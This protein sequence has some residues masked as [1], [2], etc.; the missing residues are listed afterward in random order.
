MGASL[1][2]LTEGTNRSRH[3]PSLGDI[4]ESCVACVFMYLTLLEICNVVR[5]NRAFREIPKPLEEGYLYYTKTGPHRHTHVP[6]ISEYCK[7]QTA[8]KIQ[9]PLKPRNPI[10]ELWWLFTISACVKLLLIP[11]YKSTDFEVHRHWLAITHSLPLSQ[12]Y[13]DKTSILT[14]DYPPFFTYFERFLSVFANLI[15]PQIVHLQKG[16][17][18]SSNTVLYFQRISVFGFDEAKDDL[19][20][21]DLVAN[22]CD[23]GP[24]AFPVQWV[25]AWDFIDFAFM[26]GGREGLDGWAYFC[27]A[28]VLQ[29]FVCGHGACLF[30]LVE[31]LL[32]ESL[33]EGFLAKILV[34][35]GSR[36][37]PVGQPIAITVEDADDI[38]NLPA[39]VVS[40]SEVKEDIPPPQNVKNEEGVQD[41]SF[42]GINTSEL[43][44]HIVF[45]MPALSP[46]MSQGNIFK[47]RKKEGD[48]I[49]VGDIICE[50]EKDKATIE[51]EFLEEGC[52]QAHVG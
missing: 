49:E 7:A 2:N 34:P 11:A 17:N 15:D 50:I 6:Q 5:L 44:P 46:T 10:T 36:D 41:T 13:S 14:L 32:L 31:A 3:G 45:E 1:S 28:I 47:W 33:E 38:Q 39:N 21:G 23:C 19:G 22:S 30:F 26:F 24:F 16:L 27:Y 29:A 9:N 8:P 35:E 40:G 48:K 37:V 42:V 4:P 51:Y 25:F 43:P 18:Y 12:W 20:I 52:R